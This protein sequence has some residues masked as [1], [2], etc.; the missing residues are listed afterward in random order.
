MVHL[1][2]L[3]PAGALTAPV[4]LVPIAKLP[5]L[6]APHHQGG[7]GG[8]T[9]G[10]RGSSTGRPDAH[11]FEANL[12]ATSQLLASFPGPLGPATNKDKVGGAVDQ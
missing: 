10:S 2:H 3:P 12:E 11:R 8:G 6:L 5:A 1:P 9:A 4:S 7:D